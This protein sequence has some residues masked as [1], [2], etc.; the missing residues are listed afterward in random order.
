MKKGPPEHFS[1][2]WVAGGFNNR[3]ALT[4]GFP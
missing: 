1:E 2:F 4:F 3:M